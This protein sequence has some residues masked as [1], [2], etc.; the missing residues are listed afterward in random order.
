MALSQVLGTGGTA[1][2][3]EGLA[4]VA[5]TGATLTASG[6]T[7][8][9]GSNTLTTG[10]SAASIGHNNALIARELTAL[11]KAVATLIA[12]AKAVDAMAS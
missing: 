10:A 5:Y 7:A 8:T 1:Y 9:G 2:R 6:T 3:L 11:N 12:N 4:K